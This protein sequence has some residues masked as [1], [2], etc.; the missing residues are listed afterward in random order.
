M[1]NDRQFKVRTRFVA[2]RGVSEYRATIGALIRPDDVVLELGCEW[3]TTTKLLASVAR[4][5]IGTDVSEECIGR[6][7][8]SHPCVRF[9]VLDAFD[10]R[11]AL[12]LGEGFTVVYVDLSGFSGYRSLLDVIALLQMYATVL[13]PRL[14]VTKS[15]AL[16]H[17]AANCEAWGSS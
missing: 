4:T 13:R 8:R 10:V 17:F 11:A 1:A 15:G 7:R 9:E 3:G 16:K 6:A 5:V 12:D 2:T 14:I